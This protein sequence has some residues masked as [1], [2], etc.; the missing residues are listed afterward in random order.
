[1]PSSFLALSNNALRNPNGVYDL[2]GWALMDPKRLFT[3][4]YTE[5][6][7]VISL[8]ASASLMYARLPACL[9]AC[10]TDGF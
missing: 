10:L 7:L 3:D 6:V 5:L 9:P 2:S 8:R 1:M 4:S